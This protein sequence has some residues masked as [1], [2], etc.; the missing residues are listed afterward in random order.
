VIDSNA[1]RRERVLDPI[2]RMSEILFGLIMV[3]SFTGSISV[4]NSGDEE[5]R[6]VL[7]GAIGCNL[8]WGLIDAVMYL[9]ALLIERS[10]NRA[11][12]AAV[13]AT[14]DPARGRKLIA[15]VLP[16]PLDALFGEEGLEVARAKLVALPE[17]VIRPGLQRIDCLRALGVFL[18]VFLSTFPVVLPFLLLSNLPLAMRVSNG[19]A[20]AMLFFTGHSL[21]KHAGIGPLRTGLAMVA[22]G[23]VLVALTI[24]LGG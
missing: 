9:M 21:G 5:L 13:R 19:V 1:K 22:T 23:V 3:L 4:A 10:R 11:I 8:A 18:L 14:G 2:E 7:I 16:E 17:Q 12:G 15:E 6:S 20:I 24:A